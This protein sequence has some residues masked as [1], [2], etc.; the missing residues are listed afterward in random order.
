MAAADPYAVVEEALSPAVFAVL[1]AC[2]R[3]ELQALHTML[4]PRAGA[5]ALLKTLYRSFDADVRY[6]GKA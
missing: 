5:R 6:R 4:A 3:R 1:E 2:S